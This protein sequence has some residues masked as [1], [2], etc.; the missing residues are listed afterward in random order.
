MGSPSEPD[1]YDWDD[2]YDEVGGVQDNEKDK[3]KYGYEPVGENVK[4]SKRKGK[5]GGDY[6][7][8][9]SPEDSDFE[10]PYKVEE[11]VKLPIKVGDVVM[12]GRFK[13]KKVK[14]KSI[15]VNDKGDLLINGR[16]ALKFRLPS[17]DKVLLPK[18]PEIDESTIDRFLMSVDFKKIVEGSTGFGGAPP[19]DLPLGLVLL[20]II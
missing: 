16:P 14:V 10:E 19:D 11:D 5:D 6:R 12:M 1:T 9:D 7:K 18:P 4:V 8:Y 2:D 13:N 20:D 3:K 17:N 15:D